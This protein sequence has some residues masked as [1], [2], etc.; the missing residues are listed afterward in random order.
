M[1]ALERPTAPALELRLLNEHDSIARA[2]EMLD[3]VLPVH[4]LG[5]SASAGT[6]LV[7]EELLA[8][9]IAYGFPRGGRHEILVTVTIEPDDVVVTLT[10]DGAPFDPFAVAP[11]PTPHSLAEAT[12]GGNGLRL[13]R[14]VTRERSYQRVGDRYRIQ[15]RVAR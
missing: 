11:A 12:I 3:A 9:A 6:R 13:V 10:D 7:I 8:N 1:P 5:E 14:A 4:S 15:L 2:H